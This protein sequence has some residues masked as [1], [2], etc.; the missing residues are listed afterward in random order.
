MLTNSEKARR[1]WNR[2]KLI[3]KQLEKQKA[4]EAFDWKTRGSEWELLRHCRRWEP[5][6]TQEID[7]KI[8]RWRLRKEPMS[9]KRI[10]SRLQ[11][12]WVVVRQRGV[13]L[14]FP[15]LKP[16]KELSFAARQRL[17]WRVD[18]DTEYSELDE[19]LDHYINAQRNK[20]VNRDAG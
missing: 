15:I 18:D 6:F 17:S 10:G 11:I 13:G 19:A 4:P 2:R 8:R 16:K 7:A 14:G 3:Y 12:P 1:F 9:W 5:A 20:E